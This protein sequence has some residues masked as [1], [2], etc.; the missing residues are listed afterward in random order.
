M[1]IGQCGFQ[2][3]V[4]GVIC[5]KVDGKGGGCLQITIQLNLK[6][7]AE[8]SG[9]FQDKQKIM[10]SNSQTAPN[11]PLSDPPVVQTVHSARDVHSR[12]LRKVKSFERNV[13]H[14]P[15]HEMRN[16]PGMGMAVNKAVSHI[17]SLL[18]YLRL[19][20]NSPRMFLIRTLSSLTSLKRSQIINNHNPQCTTPGN[21]Q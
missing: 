12:P 15:L 13:N 18:T 19:S 11:H 9:H 6:I 2:L 20:S 16:G 14:S 21:D 3:S 17:S 7:A 4:H 8:Y 10:M 1:Q 5:A